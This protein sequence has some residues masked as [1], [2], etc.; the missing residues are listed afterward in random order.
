MV[1]R[2]LDGAKKTLSLL[3]LHVGCAWAAIDLLKICEEAK[4]SNL[5]RVDENFLAEQAGSSVG[6]VLES[7][8]LTAKATMGVMRIGRIYFCER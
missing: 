8:E 3:S 5:I 1:K 4:M 2:E 6:E 7:P